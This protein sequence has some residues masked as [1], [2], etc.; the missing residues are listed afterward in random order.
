MLGCRLASG[1]QEMADLRRP[2]V[3]CV[4]TDGSFYRTVVHVEALRV[5][6]VGARLESLKASCDKAVRSMGWEER[7]QE[8]DPH[9]DR[10]PRSK[11]CK[12]EREEIV[13]RLLQNWP[14]S[15]RVSP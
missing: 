9:W 2:A 8:G 4:G 10:G 11:E 6:A 13:E 5:G 1:W 7:R 14:S 12:E 3:L 15:C